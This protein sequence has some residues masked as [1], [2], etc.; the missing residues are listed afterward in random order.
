MSGEILLAL[1]GA[2]A[3][4]TINAPERLNALNLPMWQQMKET[5]EALSADDDL[6]CIVLTGAGEK[7]FAAGADIAEFENERSNMDQ[8]RIYGAR[9]ADA[10][11][12]VAGCRHP[13][14][15]LIQGACVGGG[16][17]LI[18]CADMR[19][20]GAGCR[21][22]I[23]VNRLGLVV[24]YDELRGLVELVG[25]AVALEIALEGRVFGA[26]EALA[27]GIVNRLVPDDQVEEEA[28]AAARRIAAG[29]PLV[30]RWHKKFVN[31]L[32]DPTPLSPAENDESFA[33]FGTEDFQ[34]GYKAFLAKEKPEFDGR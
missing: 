16:M 3:T 32:L 22:G 11:A 28:Y 21:F 19:I 20:A 30:A 6:R 33:C 23:P 25:K 1:D 14:V 12:T 18:C 29:A 34:T 7:A 26:E 9:V 13:V 4:V 2:I 15:A 10:L 24:A 27:K 17:E 8:A 31:R 5:F